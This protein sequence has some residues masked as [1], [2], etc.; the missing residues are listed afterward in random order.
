MWSIYCNQHTNSSSSSSSSEPFTS[1]S[2]PSTPSSSPSFSSS[3]FSSTPLPIIFRAR[4]VVAADGAMSRLARS[5]GVVTTPPNT[6]FSRS[7]A[8]AGTHNFRVDN[9][10]FYPRQMLPGYFVINREP[11]DYLNLSCILLPGP[12]GSA[13]SEDLF[14][15]YK[16]LVTTDP[17]I[18]AALGPEVV[19]SP[20]QSCTMRVGG[21]PR[22]Y[23]DHFLVVGD[24]AGHVDPLTGEGL[25]YGLEAGKLAA[26]TL[27][28][29]LEMGDL[30]ERRLKVYHQRWRRA[31]GWDFA[32]SARVTEWFFNYPLLLDAAADIIRRNGEEFIASWSL[33]RT[34]AKPKLWY[35]RPDVG[36]SILLVALLRWL[37]LRNNGTTLP[38]SA[39]SSTNGAGMTVTGSQ[40]THSWL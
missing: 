14:R 8:K 34:G 13:R 3:T 12:P 23:S 40:S 33:V 25:Q 10:L 9:V 20:F 24:A 36:P 26:L 32:I 5:V 37:K 35:L 2:S 16:E 39:S 18:T 31:F 7:F 11:E 15:I 21:V 6:V 30:S 38:T 22:S 27:V 17:G 1:P 4:V 19:L 29:S 28:E